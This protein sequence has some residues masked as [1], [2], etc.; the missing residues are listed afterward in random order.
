MA[1]TR[2][3]SARVSY[4]KSL[5]AGEQGATADGA[6]VDLQGFEGAVAIAEVGL[7]GGTSTPTFPLALQHAPD[8]G[9]GAAGTYAD[10][11]AGDLEGTQPSDIVAATDQSTVSLG[12]HGSNRFLRWQVGAVTG[13]SPTL[14]ISAGV[15]RA[16]ARR[17]GGTP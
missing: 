8:D 7:I 16:W 17:S 11:P 5:E 3:F 4:A 14:Q 1:I 13:T 9:T 2:G 12:Y 6:D 10:V 15:V